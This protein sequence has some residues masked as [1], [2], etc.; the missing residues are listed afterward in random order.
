PPGKQPRPGRGRPLFHNPAIKHPQ[1]CPRATPGLETIRGEIWLSLGLRI[2]SPLEVSNLVGCFKPRG[3]HPLLSSLGNPMKSRAPSLRRHY[4]ASTV[5]LRPSDFSL[6][7][8]GFGLPL[9]LAIAAI[10]RDQRDLPR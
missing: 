6:A 2:E 1:A 4:P 3:N 7:C 10:T 9:Y 5:L 8:L